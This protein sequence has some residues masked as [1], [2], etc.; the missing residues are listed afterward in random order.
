MITNAVRRACSPRW[1]IGGHHPAALHGGVQ[2][3]SDGLRAS[4]P[5]AFRIRN[6]ASQMSAV[7][8]G[9]IALT[10][11]ATLRQFCHGGRKSSAGHEAKGVPPEIPFLI[12]GHYTSCH[13]WPRL[14]RLGLGRRRGRIHRQLANV[15]NVNNYNTCIARARGELIHILHGDDW[16]R[17]GFYSTMEKA[18]AA[19]PR[20]GAAFCRYV[21]SDESSNGNGS[22]R[23]SS[24]TAVSSTTGLRRSRPDSGCS[25]R[26]WSFDR[27]Y[28]T[29]SGL[30]ST[31]RR[32]YAR[33]SVVMPKGSCIG[34]TSPTA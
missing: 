11:S 1:R 8:C 24:R 16:V 26:P 21:A 25:R 14:R 17:P 2:P 28:T 33:W 5:T 10:A 29:T 34:Y 19:E 22:P 31:T 9:W 7:G 6:S 23:R 13:P 3:L 15:G 18:F 12:D 30:R 4:L 20:I 27:R 32:M